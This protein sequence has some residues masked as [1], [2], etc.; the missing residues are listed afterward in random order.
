MTK[1]VHHNARRHMLRQQ[2]RGSGVPEVVET[3]PS[4]DERVLP[5]DCKLRGV[6]YLN[7]VVE[8]EH[9]F[10]KRRFERCD[11]SVRFSR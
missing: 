2:E 6:K 3:V 8:Q 10:I 9:R 5:K 1:H 7:N 4:Q 11:A